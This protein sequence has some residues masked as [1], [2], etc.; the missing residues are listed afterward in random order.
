MK[1]LYATLLLTLFSDTFNDST[2]FFLI[3]IDVN[4]QLAQYQIALSDEIYTG[5]LR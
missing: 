1:F 3:V 4:T 5:L 2:A